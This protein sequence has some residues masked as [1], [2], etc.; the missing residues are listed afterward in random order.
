MKA[1]KLSANDDLD[2]EA[3]DK[4]FE[5]I[6][7]SESIKQS[8]ITAARKCYHEVTAKL[9]AI[10]SKY[11]A[12]PFNIKKEACNIKFMAVTT[13]VQVQAH[14]VSGPVIA[15]KS[16]FNFF[17]NPD[18]PE[19][20]CCRQAGMLRINSLDGTMLAQRLFVHRNGNESESGVKSSRIKL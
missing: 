8:Y 1:L 12:E 9:P 11:E 4:Y 19:G 16:F 13:C 7:D 6:F 14:L 3:H 20:I 15:N 10:I 5:T 18:L 17:L 2:L